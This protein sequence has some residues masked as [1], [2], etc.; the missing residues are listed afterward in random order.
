M[1]KAGVIEGEKYVCSSVQR[2]VCEIA[3]RMEC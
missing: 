2:K 3:I 1:C